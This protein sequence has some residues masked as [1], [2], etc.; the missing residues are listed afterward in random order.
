MKTKTRSH[1]TIAAAGAVGGHEKASLTPCSIE[2]PIRTIKILT[3]Q[4][5]VWYG[6]QNTLESSLTVPMVVHPH[7]RR[8]P[9]RSPAEIR[10]DVFIL[11]LET[12]R[13]VCGTIKRIRESAP[14]SKIVLLCGF[15]DN[16]RTRKAF[17]SGVDGIIL[18]VQPPSVVLAVIEALYI[19]A[20]DPAQRLRGG[21][22]GMDD[23]ETT[24]DIEPQPS[25]RQGALTKRERAIVQLAGL[26]LSNQDIADKLSIRDRTVR[27]HMTNIFDKLGVRNRQK[28]IAR[29]HQFLPFSPTDRKPRLTTR[30]A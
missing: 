9:D 11:D 10:A 14:T 23:R 15:E 12:V 19:S 1:C 26:G 22:V 16:R 24:A 29:A 28:L 27:H 30:C 6:L 5:L 18:F 21:S 13:N 25:D 2:A 17:A 4:W 7:P 8:T 20:N 3:D